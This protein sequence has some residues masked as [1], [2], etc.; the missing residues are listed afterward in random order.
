MATMGMSVLMTGMSAEAKDSSNS[1]ALVEGNTAFALNLYS[2]LKET[3]GNLFFSP[4]SISTALALTYAGARENTEKQ[5]AEVLCFTLD[6]KR[7]HPAFASIEARLKAIQ[8]KGDVQLSVANALWPQKDYVFLEDFLELT[9]KNYGAIITP[10]NYKSAHE[11]ARIT[12]NKWVEQKTNDKIKEL[13]KKGILDPLIRLVLTNA[14]YFKGNWADRF[15]KKLTEDAMFHLLPGKSIKVPM[16][17]QKQKFGYAEHEN[18]QILELPYVGEE[19]SMLVLLP[20]KVDGLTELE[21]KLTADNLKKWTRHLGEREVWVFLPKFE[22]TSAF[23]L[24]KTLASM[25]MPDAFSM[26]ADFSGMDGTQ[27][28][29]I[30]AVIHKAFIAVDEQGTEAAAATGVVIGVKSLP[31]PAPVFRADHPFMFLIREN[32][33]NSILFFGRVVDPTM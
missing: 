5:M 26:N 8:K 6:Q 25:G 3:E 28:L 9:K 12:I 18:L 22:M 10:L 33:S 1:E 24:D 23:R 30:S 16:M 11:A 31:Q 17:N 13:I 4:Y 19:L 2:K 14:I 7:L 27:K 20:K 21:N 15:D 32:I 29:N